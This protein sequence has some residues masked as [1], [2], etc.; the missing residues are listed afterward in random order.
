MIGIL[1]VLCMVV[2]YMILIWMSMKEDG[3]KEFIV[4]K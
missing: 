1:R 3:G 2:I 4:I